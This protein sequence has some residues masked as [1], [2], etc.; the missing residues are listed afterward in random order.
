MQDVKAE[1]R[2][3]NSLPTCVGCDV[4]TSSTLWV[5]NEL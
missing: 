4:N 3:A 2:S 5:H 1:T